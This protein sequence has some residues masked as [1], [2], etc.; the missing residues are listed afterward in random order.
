MH[1][2][3]KKYVVYIAEGMPVAFHFGPTSIH[4]LPSHLIRSI[5]L[6]GWYHLHHPLPRLLWD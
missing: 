3:I 2:Y 1:F 4:L 5:Q 6:H